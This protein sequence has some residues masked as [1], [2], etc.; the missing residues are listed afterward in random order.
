MSAAISIRKN[1]APALPVV[2]EAL[3]GAQEVIEA[4]WQKHDR[5][6]RYAFVDC[7]PSEL[8]D[9]IHRN[10]N[11]LADL[12]TFQELRDIS[13]ACRTYPRAS[14]LNVIT[15]SIATLVGSFPHANMPDPRTYVRMLIADAKA[16]QLPDVVVS[17]AC[18]V[19]RRTLQYPPP[20]AS[21]LGECELQM[22][23]WHAYGQHAE[24]LIRA[25]EKLEHVIAVQQRKL[26]SMTEQTP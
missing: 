15:E 21:F 3:A 19:M 6:P 8:A 24:R 5:E 9:C 11:L 18:T 7:T 2:S 22:H 25:R 13:A 4:H 17:H 14:S 16:L 20:I 26:Q 23:R 1:T 10:E 12:P